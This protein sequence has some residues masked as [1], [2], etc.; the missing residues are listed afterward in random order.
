MATRKLLPAAPAPIVFTRADP[1][2]LAQFDPATKRCT[3]RCGPHAD[4]PRSRAERA[5]LCGDCEIAA[6]AVPAVIDEKAERLRFIQWHK[7]QFGRYPVPCDPR[8]V[9]IWMGAKQE[10]ASDQEPQAAPIDAAA[11]SA[12]PWTV[13]SDRLP[14]ADKLVLVALVDGD[15]LPAVLDGD[16]WRDGT[17]WQIASALIT[18]WCDLPAAPG[19]GAQVNGR[20]Y[21][22]SNN[23]RNILCNSRDCAPVVAKGGEA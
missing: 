14:D 10:A 17:A 23:N 9:E 2:A 12:T 16:V 5:F 21:S 11:K 19:Y 8:H 22:L 7:D 20:L 13:V 18:H 1:A 3:M 6:P 4:D 15:V